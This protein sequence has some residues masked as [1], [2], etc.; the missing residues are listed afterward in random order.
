[1]NGGEDGARGLFRHG[2]KMEF[3][4]VFAVVYSRQT[5]FVIFMI[6]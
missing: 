3:S 4:Q 5:I 1:M 6:Q 2:A